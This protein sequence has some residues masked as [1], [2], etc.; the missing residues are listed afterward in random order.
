MEAGPEVDHHREWDHR[1]HDAGER[2]GVDGGAFGH[3]KAFELGGR[4]V[5]PLLSHVGPQNGEDAEAAGPHG[6][7]PGEL[8]EREFGHG[9]VHLVVGRAE[10]GA[11]AAH[12]HGHDEVQQQE[13][14][15][16]EPGHPAS[17]QEVP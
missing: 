3:A 4:R 15:D 16:H 5:G 2:G 9:A 10:V 1:H 13:D 7:G 12:H 11:H 8:R 6:A 14:A 17:R